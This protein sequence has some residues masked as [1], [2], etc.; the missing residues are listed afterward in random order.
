MRVNLLDCTLRD[1]GFIN[2]WDFGASAI[3]NIRARLNASGIDMVELGFINDSYPVNKDCSI[4][5]HTKYLKDVFAPLPAKRAKFLA[6]VIMGECTLASIGPRAET[7]V[8][9]IRVVF[10]KNN[11]DAAFEFARGCKERGYEVFLQP[12]SVTDYDEEAMLGLIGRAN[13]FKP[14]ALYIVDTYGLLDKET[15]FRYIDLIDGNLARDILIGYHSHNNFQQ[16][17]ATATEFIERVKRHDVVVDCSLFGMGKGAGNLNTELIVDYLNRRH[18]AAYDNNQ[19]LEVIDSEI[20]KIKNKY[21]WGYSLTGFIAA[22]NNCHPNYVQYLLNKRGLSVGSVNRILKKIEKPSLTNYDGKLI[23]RLFFEYQSV[24]V[25]DGGAL[26]ALTECFR[27]KEIL[28]LAPGATLNTHR[29]TVN[30]FIAERAPLV[31]AVNHLP[32]SFEID[33]CFINNS[34]RFAQLEPFLNGRVIATSNITEAL[35]PV[36]FKICYTKLLAEGDDTVVADNAVLMLFEL[37]IAC[38]V[39]NVSVAGFD[40]FSRNRENYVNRYLSYNT[41]TDTETQNKLLTEHVRKTERRLNIR[42]L[43]PS[44]YRGDTL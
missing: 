2:N 32:E 40:G 36:E 30:A 25:D 18:G 5:P 10:K 7:P 6:M 23:E 21:S 17:Y 19:I 11:I 41:N 8:D 3:T 42:F 27:G 39:R 44:I 24:S 35:R 37:L 28:L 34:K 13:E 16:S 29:D 22:S 15:L 12:A 1:G 33:F 31:I 9:G 38:G 4:V 26:A 20:L 43:T 14:F